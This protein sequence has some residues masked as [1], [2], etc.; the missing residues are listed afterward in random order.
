MYN[1]EYEKAL[2]KYAYHEKEYD[3]ISPKVANVHDDL[4]HLV[5][6]DYLEEK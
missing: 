6:A 4:P 5:H 1:K 2:I 3:F